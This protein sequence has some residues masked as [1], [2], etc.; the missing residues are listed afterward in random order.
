MDK[1]KRFVKNNYKLLILVFVLAIIGHFYFIK[2][3]FLGNSY[4]VGPGD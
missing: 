3:Q 4:M 1:V 2:N